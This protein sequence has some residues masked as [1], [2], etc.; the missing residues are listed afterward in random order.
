[1]AK[2]KRTW[3]EYPNQKKKKRGKNGGVISSPSVS[4]LLV[5]H[6]KPSPTV[7]PFNNI[8]SQGR[9]IR[10]LGVFLSLHP[11]AGKFLKS[12]PLYG[13]DIG[14]TFPIR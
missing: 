13:V 11:S 4:K 3:V 2:V 1:M 10:E 6:V 14:T 8:Q 5:T 12:E 7:L 9:D